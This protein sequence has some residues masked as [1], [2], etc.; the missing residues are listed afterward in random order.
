MKKLL[1]T[2]LLCVTAAAFAV[3]LTACGDDNDGGAKYHVYMPDGAPAVALA[4][5]MH[6]GYADTDF[7][8][9]PSTLIGTKVTS[10]DADLAIMPINAAAQLYN[11]KKADIVMLSVN[12]HGNLYIVK[13]EENAESISLSD[14]AGKRLGTIGAGGV[15]EL[16]IKML[17]E[18][19]EIGYEF[20]DSAVS[21]K[22]AISYGENAG[23]L[24]ASGVDYMLL[25]EPAVTTVVNKFSATIVMDLQEQWNAA[26]GGDYPQACLVAKKSIVEKDGKYISSF[27]AALK[28]TDDWAETHAEETL[29]TIKSHM[30]EGY[31]SDL[32]M[33]TADSIKR[34]NIE[35][36][37]A[38]DMIESC[39]TYF[40]RLT[41]L[42]T[43]L[44]TPV[45]GK[46]PDENF[47]YKAQ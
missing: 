39:A 28:E 9:V 41:K 33:L 14:L 22:V 24:M 27:L 18:K 35:T 44:G 3:P 16:T 45:L 15:P 7:T 38:Q 25:P 11:G 13:K 29:G 8:V 43:D 31:Q 30:L 23:G 40:D 5:F 32:A 37:Y 17:L 1:S 36:V 47:Y 46:A 4:S 26:F 34:C 21:G 2:V 42:K 19:A 6:N 10:G 12:T 20:S